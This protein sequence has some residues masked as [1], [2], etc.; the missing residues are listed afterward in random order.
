M[1][2]LYATSTVLVTVMAWPVYL[3]LAV[4]SE[5]VLAVFGPSFSTGAS[6]LSIIALASLASNLGQIWRLG[7]G[8]LPA[9]PSDQPPAEPR[10]TPT[11]RTRRDDDD[12]EWFDEDPLGRVTR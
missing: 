3:T 8:V 4:F 10:A 9:P 11:R 1:E 12:D 6:A 7:F 5:D 2:R